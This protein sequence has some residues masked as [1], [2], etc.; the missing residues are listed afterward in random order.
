V[1]SPSDRVV[2]E[3]QG[4]VA[5]VTLNRPERRN[6]LDEP[7]W[8]A[9]KAAAERLRAE[10]LRAVVITGRE[11][12]FSTGMDLQ[13]D[14]P[15][16]AD[17]GEAMTGG[18]RAAVRALLERL[19]GVFAAVEALPMPTVAAINGAAYG[20]GLELA[21]CCDL[22]VMD[23]S[24]KACLPECRI[25][26]MPDL[27]GTVR[28]SRLLGRAR[29]LDLIATARAVGAEEALRLGLV[30]RVAESGKSLEV[31]LELAEA[32]AQNGPRAVRQVKRTVQC[33]E[34]ASLDEALAVETEHAIDAILS[35]EAI[36]GI[37]AF[38]QRRPPSFGDVD[39]EG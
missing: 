13:P 30:D 11:T 23:A 31:A 9:L 32:I 20:G 22:R 17:F 34:G 35:G 8:D 33:I 18:D 6:A 15:L 7:L 25:G 36:E 14:N 16:M 21:L 5:I 37:T 12:S 28:A 4:S 29:A 19:K 39:P 1:K 26:L 2:V 38:G 27:G 3:H 10:P 24:A